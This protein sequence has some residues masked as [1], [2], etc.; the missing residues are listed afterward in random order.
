MLFQGF[1]WKIRGWSIGTKFSS[2]F[3]PEA[4]KNWAGKTGKKHGTFSMLHGI[5]S[6]F[7]MEKHGIYS[8]LFHVHG[9]LE[10]KYG[11]FSRVFH[12]SANHRGWTFYHGK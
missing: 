6:M 12:V 2:L 1:P 4:E 7:S 11:F 5:F 9:V 8:M 3:Q 10:Q